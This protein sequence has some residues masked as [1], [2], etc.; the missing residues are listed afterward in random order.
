MERKF[1][2]KLTII[3][4][5][6]IG[7]C[8][9]GSAYAVKQMTADDF[10]T[11]C[12]NHIKGI[13]LGEAKKYHEMSEYVFLDVRTEKEFKRGSI[14]NAILV[15]RGLLE[16]KVAKKIPDKNAKIIVYCKSGKRSHLSA[17]TL[18]KMGYKNVVSMSGGWKAWV[19]AGYP[20]G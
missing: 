1:F 11:D 12:G 2:S 19:K 4:A 13:S 17:C 18:T 5:V 20:V 8:F 3:V 14:P 9:M 10:I 15:Q 16:F 7:V 6:L